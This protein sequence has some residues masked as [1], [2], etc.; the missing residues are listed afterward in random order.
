MSF[1]CLLEIL[2]DELDP[3]SAVRFLRKNHIK[4]EDGNGEEI[5]DDGDHNKASYPDEHHWFGE[6]PDQY[7]QDAT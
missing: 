6:V 5:E 7:L 3:V 4:R 2:L 1:C